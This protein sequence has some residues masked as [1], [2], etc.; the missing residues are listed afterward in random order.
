MSQFI[1]DNNELSR[2]RTAPSL[3]TL[4]RDQPVQFRLLTNLD[5]IFTRP[6]ALAFGR[7]RRLMDSKI[8]LVLLRV[9]YPSQSLKATSVVTGS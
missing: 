4:G 9:R 5:Y 2:C 8:P 1:L 6:N 7:G 3:G